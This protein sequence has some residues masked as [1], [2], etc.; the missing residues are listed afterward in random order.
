MPRRRKPA[1]L[2]LRP[3]EGVWVI[4]DGGR[5]I[6]TGRR[7]DEL[8]AAEGDLAAYVARRHAS[9]S[10][11]SELLIDL[12]L[13]RYI[14]DRGPSQKNQEA[15][16]SSVKALVPF[17][18]TK[19]CD[20]VKGS[21]CRA[22]ASQRRRAPGTV[23]RELATLQAALNHAHAEGLLIH[24]VKVT[25]PPAGK[26]RSRW[27]TRTEAA[28]LLRAAAPHLRRWM[29]ISLYTGRRMEAVLSLRWQTSL[30]SGWVDADAGVIH[31]LGAR[32]AETT[33]RRGSVKVGPRL[34]AHLRRWRRLDG[35]GATHVVTY[36]PRP[37]LEPRPVASIKTALQAAC[38]RTAVEDETGAVVTP[39]IECSAHD[40]KR[41]AVTWAF[42]AGMS[43]ER[44]EEFFDTS[45]P[46][47]RAA[48]RQ[49]SPEHQAGSGAMIER[50]R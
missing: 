49:H 35:P 20:A 22:Y 44:A 34:A 30:D 5:Q 18:G 45:G 36:A 27:L 26:P 21:T 12:V 13:A 23:R 50:S 41:T 7:A 39:P 33:K 40:F 2:W 1:R 46:T 4:L 25:L 19:T 3:D 42:R 28:R 16:A 32:Q 43:M 9:P 17:W 10:Q 48:Y 47:L 15:L 14:E 31:F 24:P 29:L 38:R 8:E 6:R 37:G 11:P